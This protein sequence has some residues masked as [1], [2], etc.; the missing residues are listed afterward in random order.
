[1]RY[2]TEPNERNGGSYHEFYRGKWNETTF[3]KKDSL[4]LHDDV[5]YSI[6]GFTSAISTVFPDYSPAGEVEI[7]MYQWR[8]IGELI[9]PKD[10][11]ARALYDE[12]D[13]WAK[14]AFD[15]DGCFTILG[16]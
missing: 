13:Q 7:S 9:N 1:M 6:D 3:W 11:D 4:L 10:S 15:R 12:I 5:L 2:C 16:I 8:Q 14:T